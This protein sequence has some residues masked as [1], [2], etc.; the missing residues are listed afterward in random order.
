[1]IFY[2]ASKLPSR[3]VVLL[4]VYVRKVA[5]G[6]GQIDYLTPYEVLHCT[7]SDRHVDAD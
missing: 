4:N 3:Y 6:T 7:S 2:L 5:S 1:M